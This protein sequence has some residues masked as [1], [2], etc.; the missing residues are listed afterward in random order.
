MYYCEVPRI[1]AT[2]DNHNFPTVAA[3]VR[4]AALLKQPL[5]L[6]LVQLASG[7]LRSSERP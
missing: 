5:K 1:G 4:M 3:I 2:T 7:M 6:A